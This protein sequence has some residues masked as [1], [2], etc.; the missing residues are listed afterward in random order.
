MWHTKVVSPTEMTVR[1]AASMSTIAN[2]TAARRDRV[3]ALTDAVVRDSLGGLELPGGD[4]KLQQVKGN[5]IGK[6]DAYLTVAM[7]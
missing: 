3:K 6:S 2:A 1:L 5:M 4:A 7:Q